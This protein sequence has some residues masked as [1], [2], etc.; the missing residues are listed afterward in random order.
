MTPVA[1]K[2]LTSLALTAILGGAAGG[3]LAGC[4][5]KEDPNKVPLPAQP[6]ATPDVDPSKSK[7]LPGAVQTR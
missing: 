4:G 2:V 1:R 5:P 6:N 7:R 3:L